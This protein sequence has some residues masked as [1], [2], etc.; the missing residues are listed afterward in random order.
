VPDGDSVGR[1]AAVRAA[2]RYSKL[3]YRVRVADMPPD[4][5]ADDLLRRVA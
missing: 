2:D 1:A 4:M 3:G 5:D